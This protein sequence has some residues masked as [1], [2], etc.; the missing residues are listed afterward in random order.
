[1]NVKDVTKPINTIGTENNTNKPNNQHGGSG[2][3][4]IG[5]FDYQLKYLWFYNYQIECFINEI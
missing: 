1:M 5:A 3:G 2:I 4:F